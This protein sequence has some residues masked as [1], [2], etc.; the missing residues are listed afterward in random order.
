VKP[1]STEAALKLRK[2]DVED[3][4]LVGLQRQDKILVDGKLLNWDQAGSG[5]HVVLLLPGIIGT[6]TLKLYSLRH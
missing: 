4:H 5:D 1:Y 3:F 2:S 6:L